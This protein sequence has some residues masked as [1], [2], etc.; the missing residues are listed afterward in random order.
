M[1]SKIHLN[2]FMILEALV[3]VG[4]VAIVGLTIYFEVSK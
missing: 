3:W 1:K 2:G 4:T